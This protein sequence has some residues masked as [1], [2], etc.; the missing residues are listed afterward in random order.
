MVNV[1]LDDGGLMVLD[2]QN[3]VF[4]PWSIPKSTW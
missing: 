4:D 2:L 3:E 1:I